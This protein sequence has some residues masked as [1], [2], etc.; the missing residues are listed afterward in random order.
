[1]S[2][3]GLLCEAQTECLASHF[4]VCEVAGP[5]RLEPAY[6]VSDSDQVLV[7]LCVLLP[8]RGESVPPGF[9]LISL[10]PDGQK[11]SLNHGDLIGATVL[12]AS[13]T[14][15]LSTP[16]CRPITNLA[17]IYA[18]RGEQ[19]PSGYEPIRRTVGNE[20]ASLNH[21][22]SGREIYLC[23]TRELSASPH[24]APLTSVAVVLR[25]AAWTRTGDLAVNSC[26][27]ARH[28]LARVHREVTCW[29]PLP[30]EISKAAK[31]KSRP[32]TSF[33]RAT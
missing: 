8:G 7:D 15:A 32:A 26:T 3:D 22:G 19:P 20:R 25:Y 23:V 10:T 13:R 28:T 14:E 30:A 2:G 29:S 17:A 5:G 16:G 9:S 4:V 33:S 31:C 24:G 21:G 1:M 12:L 18:D 6:Y 27:S 11:A